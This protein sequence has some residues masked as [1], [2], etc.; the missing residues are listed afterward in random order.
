MAYTQAKVKTNIDMKLPMGMTLTNLDQAKHLLKLE[1]N[2]YG[3]M[4]GKV[5]WHEHIKLGLLEC[6][7]LSNLLL[8]S[9]YL[10]KV[11]FS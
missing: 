5:T 10:L 1:Q 8:T 9:V 6:G 2:L 7:F 4:D 11:K 3:L